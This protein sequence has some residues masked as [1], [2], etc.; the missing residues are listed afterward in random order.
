LSVCQ[1]P[2]RLAG[3]VAQ[4][5][6]SKRHIMSVSNTNRLQEKSHAAL[7]QTG[8]KVQNFVRS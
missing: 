3:P 1:P 6:D 2:S 8:N 5:R 7:P 4:Y